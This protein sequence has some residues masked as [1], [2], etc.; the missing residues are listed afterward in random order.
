[1]GAVQKWN[2][3]G[4]LLRQA[5]EEFLRKHG[6]RGPGRGYGKTAIWYSGEQL[7]YHGQQFRRA[8]GFGEGMVGAEFS[9]E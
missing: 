2:S 6:L 3:S 8:E 1:M 7:L 9:R 5:A 4:R